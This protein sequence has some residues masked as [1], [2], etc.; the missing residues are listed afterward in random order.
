M[1]VAP[2]ELAIMAAPEAKEFLRREGERGLKFLTRLAIDLGLTSEYDYRG[3]LPMGILLY[4]YV[5]PPLSTAW[6]IEQQV[7]G[8]LQQ[9]YSWLGGVGRALD[10]GVQD[11]ESFFSRF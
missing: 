7:A 6:H 8:V 1:A 2:V 5:Y 3:W 4:H 10:A 11:I 9:L